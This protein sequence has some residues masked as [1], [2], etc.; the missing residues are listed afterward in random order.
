[1]DTSFGP[2]SLPLPARTG[3]INLDGFADLM[4]IRADTGRNGLQFTP[5]IL[6]NVPCGEKGA[7]VCERGGRRAWK[8]VRQGADG[9]EMIK[10][11]RGAA[12]VDV[13]EDGTLDVLVQ[14]TGKDGQ[15]KL[16]FVQNN[17][18]HD[19]FFLKAIGETMDMGALKIS[20]DMGSSVL[21]H[22][23][24]SGRCV[25]PNGTFY[26][27]RAREQIVGRTLL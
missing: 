16:A 27:V 12:F 22:A 19:A 14:R 1:M 7:S 17:F 24:P 10:D 26:Q 20:A 18:Y 4:L 21:N 5:T 25:A 23:C 13:D 15:G 8:I 3:D 2:S 6:M 11:A 9:L